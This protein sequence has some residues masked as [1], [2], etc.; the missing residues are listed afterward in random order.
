MGSDGFG[1]RA[2]PPSRHVTTGE[3]PRLARKFPGAVIASA[4]G[5]PRRARSSG[6]TEA[7]HA[8]QL[9]R[10]TVE[11]QAEREAQEVHL[12]AFVPAQEDA[13][14]P[15]ERELEPRATRRGSQGRAVRQEV[16]ADGCG[17]E[18]QPELGDGA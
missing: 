10:R 13:E 14:Q 3:A 6:Q 17:R 12:Q 2:E 9:E 5:A 1:S 11:V 15:E 18:V 4:A 8:R 16:L 7:A